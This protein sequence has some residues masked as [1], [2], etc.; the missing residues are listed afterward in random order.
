MIGQEQDEEQISGIDESDIERI[1]SK[2]IDEVSIAESKMVEA[3]EKIF[4]EEEEINYYKDNIFNKEDY[5]LYRA[6]IYFYLGDYEKSISDFDQSSS[7]MAHSSES[8][9]LQ[10][11]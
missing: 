10:N 2:N 8:P 3:E 6:V 1:I 4:I 7:L 9:P 5:F 11:K